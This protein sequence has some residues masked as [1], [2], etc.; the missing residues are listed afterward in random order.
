MSDVSVNPSKLPLLLKLQLAHACRSL[1][2]LLKNRIPHSWLHGRPRRRLPLIRRVLALTPLPGLHPDDF[3]ELL[4]YIAIARDAQSA[5]HLWRVFD[6]AVDPALQDEAISGLTAIG[7]DEDLDRLLKLI[8]DPRWGSTVLGDFGDAQQNEISVSFR[9]RAYRHVL[10]LFNPAHLGDQAHRIRLE[11]V[12]RALFG[13]N[14]KAASERFLTEESLQNYFLGNMIF[15]ALHPTFDD[16]PAERIADLYRIFESQSPGDN[17]DHANDL[18]WTCKKLL[19]VMGAARSSHLGPIIR[20]A[21][22]D[23]R[24]SVRD[25]AASA[26]T[27]HHGLVWPTSAI[28]PGRT[29][30]IVGWFGRLEYLEEDW[31]PIIR[32]ACAAANIRALVSNGGFSAI[33]CHDHY[34]VVWP[35]MLDAIKAQGPKCWLPIL[36]RAH[37]LYKPTQSTWTNPPQDQQ[38]ALDRDFYGNLAADGW[39]EIHCAVVNNADVVRPI[40]KAQREAMNSV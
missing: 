38:D 25:E 28:I 36:E 32:A 16:F 5:P 7:R 10:P 17:R 9:E 12:V 35:Q 4:R 3:K 2:P 18:E 1:D 20:R 30:S 21:L 24:D 29:A 22:S 27:A 6:N 11:A 15:E 13:L 14:Q 39:V 31:P 8:N 37:A 33:F 19:S 40:L 23:P 34:R 26:W